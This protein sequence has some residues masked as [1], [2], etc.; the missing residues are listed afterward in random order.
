MDRLLRRLASLFGEVSFR[1]EERAALIGLYSARVTW[2]FTTVV[3]FVWAVKDVIRTGH[4]ESQATV[5]FASQLVFWTASLYY[6][7][8]FGG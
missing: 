3:L 6:T 8:K 1:T 5:F 2:I 4:L 7:K